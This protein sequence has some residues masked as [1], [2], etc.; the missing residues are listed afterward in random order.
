MSYVLDIFRL[1]DKDDSDRLAAREVQKALRL[2]MRVWVSVGIGVGVSM[3]S[4]EQREN[5]MM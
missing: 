2:R 4:N 1:Y 5:D 3:Y